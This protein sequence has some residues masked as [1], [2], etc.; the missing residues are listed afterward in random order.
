MFLKRETV[1]IKTRNY[2]CVF[3]IFY[4][5]RRSSKWSAARVDNGAMML[6]SCKAAK[7][8]AASCKANL[9]VMK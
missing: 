2:E 6:Q 3:S 5:S 7:L 1:E 8:Q 4:D 9:D